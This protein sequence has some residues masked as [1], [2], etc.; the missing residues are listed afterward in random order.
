MLGE[1]QEFASPRGL[2]FS[3][4]RWPT[5]VAENTERGRRQADLCPLRQR[6]EQ[7]ERERSRAA[8]AQLKEAKKNKDPAR[9]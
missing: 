5:E 3:K 9:S 2:R 1:R 8:L 4:I 7:A 6:A